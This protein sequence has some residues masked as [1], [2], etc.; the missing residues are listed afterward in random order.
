MQR[1]RVII[2][3]ASV[4]LALSAGCLG[5]VF[6]ITT[7]LQYHFDHWRRP[8]NRVGGVVVSADAVFVASWYAGRIYKFDFAGTVL[9]TYDHPGSPIRIT[10][11]EEFIIVHYSGEQHVLDDP[12][13]RVIDPHG[14]TAGVHRTWWGHPVM[15]VRRPDGATTRVSLQPWYVTVLRSTYPAALWLLL[16]VAFGVVALWTRKRLRM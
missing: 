6:I 4:V 3:V 2:Y 1:V 11:R 12:A 9:S 8:L 15:V 7:E 10:Q 16:A 13:F 14:V 5:A